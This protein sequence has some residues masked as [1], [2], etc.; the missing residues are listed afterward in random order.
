MVV[1]PILMYHSISGGGAPGFRRFTLRSDLFAAQMACL[2]EQGCNTLS[3]AGLLNARR[4]K[5]LPEKPVVLTF[6]DGF[7][8]FYTDA[9]PVLQQHNAA[10]SLFIPTRYLGGTSLWLRDIGEG[11]RPLISRGQ[12]IEIANA[13]VD[14]GAHT[15]SHC[16]LDMV[17][18]TRGRRELSQSKEILEQIIGQA[19]TTFAYPY[20]HHHAEARQWVVD[21]GFQAACAVRNALSHSGD[22]L[23]AL[24][25]ITITNRTDV[26]QLAALL[27]GRG[28]PLAAPGEKLVTRLWR[29]YRIFRAR[30]EKT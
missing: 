18:P 2:R 13:G 7:L 28:L 3:V 23:F 11:G 26:R 14:C 21:A 20:G 24:A 8:D 4:Q 27:A 30:F 17:D 1:I 10:A 9:L 5:S 19:V 15:H 29:Q 6:D 22:D 16:H 25:R 12:L